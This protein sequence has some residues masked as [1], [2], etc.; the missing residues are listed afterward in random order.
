MATG[1][2]HGFKVNVEAYGTSKIHLAD[3]TKRA[4]R[5]IALPLVSKV[6]GHNTFAR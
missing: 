2:L 4:S 6:E 1:K 3:L 5:L